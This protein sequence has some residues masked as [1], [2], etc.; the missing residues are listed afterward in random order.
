MTKTTNS[1]AVSWYCVGSSRSCLWKAMVC[2]AYANPE[3]T[4]QTWKHSQFFSVFL[5][6]YSWHNLSHVWRICWNTNKSRNNTEVSTPE[7]ADDMRWH[8]NIHISIIPAMNMI[9]SSVILCRTK[10]SKP[11]I[12]IRAWIS[13]Y[14][15]INSVMELLT[16]I[17][18][19]KWFMLF[20]KTRPVGLLMRSIFHGKNCTS[21]SVN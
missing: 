18:T 17:L 21:A 3:W 8:M 16:R 2:I 15:D 14:I 20:S 19:S 9:M 13:N 11:N 12:R 4:V 10:I 5:W 6:N 7:I 1:L